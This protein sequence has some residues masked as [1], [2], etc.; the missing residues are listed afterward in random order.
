MKKFFHQI[1]NYWPLFKSLQTGL[2]TVTG[3][4]GYMSAR[5]PI[6]HWSTMV[7]LV[8]SL[9][10]SISGSTVL[11]MWYD[12]DID[13]VMNRTHHR[14]IA[15]GSVSPAEALRLGL[16]L[17]ALGVG[18]ALL[19]SPLYALVIFAGI[20]FD[21]ILYTILLKRKTC[22]SVIWGGIAGGMPILA[23]RTLGMGHLDGIGIMLA[24]A[25]L[26]WIPTHILTFSL[27]YRDDYSAASIPTFPS[28]YG[29]QF[30]RVTIAISSILAA[31]MIGAAAILIGVNEG[32]LHLLGILSGGLMILAFLMMVRPSPKLNF[33]LFKFAS[34]YMLAAMILLAL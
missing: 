21:V 13:Q 7:G 1:R 2:L 15:N 14:P 8:L 30:T 17:S 16:V 34:V 6:T 25:V 32:I 26:F 24:L 27:R 28:I 4:A 12:R 3:L 10:F 9:I 33:S 20:F 18:I 11:N 31:V 5:C 29:D 23:G 22:W 19:L